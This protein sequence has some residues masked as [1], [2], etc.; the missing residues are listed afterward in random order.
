MTVD[1]I[2]EDDR[3][4]DIAFGDLAARGIAATLGHLDLDP[5]AWDIA[6]LGCDDARI[7][8]LNAAFRGKRNATNVLSWPSEERA[9]AAPG[10]RPDPPSGDPEL[11][12]I[13]LAFETCRDEAQAAGVDLEA[14]ALHLIIHGTLHLLGY[15]HE[16]DAAA[17]LMEATEIAILCGLGVPNPYER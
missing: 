4:S 13:A 16:E 15:D 3:W 11:G 5:E 8:S 14:H 1:V 10:D 17:D 7:A 2:L 6:V 12:D 9:P